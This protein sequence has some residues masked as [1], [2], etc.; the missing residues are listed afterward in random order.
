MPGM[1]KLGIPNA[2]FAS[3]QSV[4]V[5][6]QGAGEPLRRAD[7]DR[8]GPGQLPGRA[9]VR[10]LGMPN[11]AARTAGGLVINGANTGPVSWSGGMTI[12]NAS[13]NALYLNSTGGNGNG[14]NASGNGTGSGVQGTGGANRPRDQ[15]RRRIDLR[16]R[17]Q[18]RLADVGRW[19]PSRGRRG[20]PRDES[21]SR[22]DRQRPQ[23]RGRLDV[24]RRGVGYDHGGRWD[25]HPPYGRQRDHSD[26]QRHREERCPAR[27]TTSGGTG[28]VTNITGTIT[29]TL[30]GPVASVS[31][32]SRSG[33]TTTRR[34]LAGDGRRRPP[35]RSRR[36]SSPR[37]LR[38]RSAPSPRP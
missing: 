33:P 29:G 10:P 22:R 11:S 20:L 26:G 38:R 8:A 31:R 18:G 34:L 14:L 30:A 3:G 12:A 24:G 17:L 5:Y 9:T 36:T 7:R 4:T 37:W 1:Y 15:R 21:G 2:A 28:L 32:P 35:R 16:E 27:R 25:L 23:P 13:G 19:R 6:I